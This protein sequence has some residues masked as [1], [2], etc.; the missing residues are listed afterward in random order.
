MSEYA[1][2]ADPRESAERP[3]SVEPARQ[4]R[5]K[6]LRMPK[7]PAKVSSRDCNLFFDMVDEA[8]MAS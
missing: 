7:R 1:D 4:S 5:G 6:A 2:P 8:V 3:R